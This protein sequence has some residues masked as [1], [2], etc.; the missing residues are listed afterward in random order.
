MAPSKN[1]YNTR[2]ASTTPPAPA[3]TNTTPTVMPV[4]AALAVLT[5]HGYTPEEKIP[6]ISECSTYLEQLLL[7]KN[8][9]ALKIGVKAMCS[10]LLHID[11]TGIVHAATNL[12]KEMKDD[13][14]AE[15]LEEVNEN[16]Q[17][18]AHEQMS[19][20]RCFWDES[21][22]DIRDSFALEIKSLI[23]QVNTPFRASLDDGEWPQQ[24]AE[25]QHKPTTYANI[26]QT[27]P[28]HFDQNLH[29]AAID[30]TKKLE[31][32][33][34]I[35]SDPSLTFNSL[36]DLTTN[37]I[38][39]KANTAIEEVSSV[40][41]SCP[42]GAKIVGAKRT[43]GGAIVLHP[44]SSEAG[45]WLRKKVVID[46]VNTALSTAILRPVLFEVM[47]KFVPVSI[48][49][50]SQEFLRSVEQGNGLASFDI[51]SAR[52]LKKP[53]NRHDTQKVAFMVVGFTNSEAANTFL[54]RG[55]VYIQN[56]MLQV[57]RPASSPR[58][59]L[60]CQKLDTAHIAAT[61]KSPD[62]VCGRCAGQHRTKNCKVSDATKFHCS[63]CNATG[64]GATSGT[65]PAYTQQIENVKM[66]N[67]YNTYMRFP[68]DSPR[69][70]IQSLPSYSEQPRPTSDLNDLI[71]T[72]RP[73]QRH[74]KH[75][76]PHTQPERATT[77]APVI[78]SATQEIQDMIDLASSIPL[79]TSS[80]SSA[81]TIDPA[82][83]DQ[84]HGSI[85]Q[86]RLSSSSIPL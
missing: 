81:A 40:D 45:K 69:T 22:K 8:N 49:I 13:I 47:V 44:N 32:Q 41:Q 63:N 16:I 11:A 66:K 42:L 3:S 20:M 26:L 17:L 43:R 54:D 86:N 4:A 72:R 25:T 37:D 68:T 74:R 14:K 53:E 62:D 64:H 57:E 1:V 30:Q 33:V 79:P 6:S 55:R 51:W 31:S 5:K 39:A 71:N 15:L 29:Y 46:S 75:E 61:C 7:Q 35:M 56:E 73:Q 85:S 65:C 2:S 12:M 10:I 23:Q 59:C 84:N 77:P 67:P 34:V 82:K 9:D 58:R 48:N 60:K 76:P 52:W 21:A 80:N 78:H 28:P 83:T 50:D 19:A 36:K 27:Q 38:V 18:G 24:F 70:W